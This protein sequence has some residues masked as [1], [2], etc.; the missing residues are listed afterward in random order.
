MSKAKRTQL[1]VDRE[2]QGQ[3]LLR[4][5]AYWF[6]GVVGMT[7]LVAYWQTQLRRPIVFDISKIEFWKAFGPVV[8]LSLGFVPALAYDLLRLSNRA[9]GP[10][11]RLR[12]GLQ[13]IAQGRM[14]PPLNVRNDDYW[15][16]LCDDFNAAVARFSVQGSGVANYSNGGDS[17][18][19][20]L[21]EANVR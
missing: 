20:R 9:A 8:M 16:G 5:I 15:K 10:L 18:L 14:P 11:V 7:L 12:S 6:F 21:V 1:F 19:N 3:L 4:A 2:L 13:E 17:S